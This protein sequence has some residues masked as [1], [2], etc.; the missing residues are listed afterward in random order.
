MTHC[1]QNATL[2]EKDGGVFGAHLGDDDGSGRR[3]PF[4]SDSFPYGPETEYTAPPR[5]RK[6]QKLRQD[7][8]RERISALLKKYNMVRQN[9]GWRD[10]PKW[11]TKA[12]RKRKR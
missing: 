2:F 4:F 8:R 3:T 7:A 9:E 10:N 5:V 1:P 12:T 11:K 6:E